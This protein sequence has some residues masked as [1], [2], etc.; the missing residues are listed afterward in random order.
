MALLMVALPRNLKPF[1]E[2][3]SSKSEIISEGKSR[4]NEDP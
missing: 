4:D 1:E 2:V 3:G